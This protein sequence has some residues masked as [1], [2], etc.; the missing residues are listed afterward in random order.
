MANRLDVIFCGEEDDVCIL[1]FKGEEHRYRRL[2]VQEFD[3]TRKRMSVI[4]QFPDNTIWLLCKG[5][6]STVLPRCSFG[7]VEETENHI[8][9]YAMVIELDRHISNIFN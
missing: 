1:Q 2:H 6:E 3:S 7:P 4:Y 5:A 9:D 8:K